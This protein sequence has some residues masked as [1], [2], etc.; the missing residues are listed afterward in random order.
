MSLK[1]NIEDLII[2]YLQGTISQAEEQELNSWIQA[3]G[4]NQALFDQLTDTK[5]VNAGLEKIYAYDEEKGWEKIVALAPHY[6]AGNEV[7]T[8]KV[9]KLWRPAVAAASIIL[10]LGIGGYLWLSRPSKT[11]PAAPPDRPA[12]VDVKA[13][14]KNRAAI[15]LSNG[16]IVYLDSTANGTLAQ[17]AGVSVVKL[18]DGQLAYTAG[19]ASHTLEY[20]TLY[21]PRGSKIVNLTLSDGPKVWLNSETT[22][23]YPVDFIGSDRKVEVSGEAYFEVAQ[24]PSKPFKVTAQKMEVEVL[25]THFNVNAYREEDIISTTLLEGSVKLNSG[26]NSVRIRPGEQ[27]RFSETFDGAFKIDPG[28]DVEKVL[29]WKKGIFEFDDFELP[30][31]MR[32][33][34][35]WYDLDI[36]YEKRPG[37]AKYGGGISKEAPL[38]NVLKMLE[39][40]G[41]RFRL[42]GNKIFVK[43]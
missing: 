38:S 29:A 24:M 37:T 35:R 19:A 23:R 22:L 10:C 13:P 2:K 40:Y 27:A 16:N 18:A 32:Q 21:N 20:N 39:A 33:I 28:V 7:Q 31:I 41:I 36:V 5:S 43:P 4:E 3:S 11:S 12:C 30:A 8:G 34:S 17:Q 42:E 25:G 1:I 6:D 9:R 26:S 14:D 15:T